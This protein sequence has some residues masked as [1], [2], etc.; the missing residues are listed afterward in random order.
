MNSYIQ[1]NKIT[2]EGIFAY[3]EAMKY[4]QVNDL[5]QDFYEF[6]QNNDH[7]LQDIFAVYLEIRDSVPLELEHRFRNYLEE[8]YA[9][10]GEPEL[11][12]LGGPLHET[13][14]ISPPDS[15]ICINF[16]SFEFE[17]PADIKRHQDVKITLNNK[18]YG[19]ERTFYKV[20]HQ[21]SPSFRIPV[22]PDK[23]PSGKYEWVV[24]FSDQ[25]KVKGK[26]YITTN[27]E[28]NKFLQLQN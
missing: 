24:T 10:K 13:L 19:V 20:I 22:P 2:T 8:K 18:R 5:E 26:I 28:L 16:I 21:S 14:V 11:I 9:H 23:Y 7:V 17:S 4:D 25:E 6:V 12:L 3:A 1:N 15:A 27:Q